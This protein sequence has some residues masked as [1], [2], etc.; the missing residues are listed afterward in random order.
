MSMSIYYCKSFLTALRNLRL[1]DVRLKDAT[2]TNTM[3]GHL[4]AALGETCHLLKQNQFL[5]VFLM[6]S[7][8]R[9]S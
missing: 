8:A 3:R 2:H 7:H 9:N 6:V 4:V 1:K 5:Q